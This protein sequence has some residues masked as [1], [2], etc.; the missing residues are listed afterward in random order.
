MRETATPRA[1]GGSPA[2][3]VAADAPSPASTVRRFERLGYAIAATD[4]VAIVVAFLLAYVI[5]FGPGVPPASFA[6]VIALVPPVWLT[7]F[8][9]WRLYA[10]HRFEPAEQFRRIVTAVSILITIVATLSFWSKSSYSRLWIGLSWVLSLVLVLLCHRAWHRWLRRHRAHGDLLLRTLIVGTNKEADALARALM[11]REAGFEPVGYVEF[12]PVD[13]RLNGLSI[14][15]TLDH[16][17]EAIERT[18]ADCLFVASTAVTGREMRAVSS[19]ARKAG[20]ELRVT[21]NLPETLSTRIAVQPIGR[22]MTLTFQPLG[23]SSAQAALKRSM[24]VGLSVLGL[25]LFAPVLATVAVAIRLGSS[26]PVLFRHERVGRRGRPFQ[27]LKF[28]TMV[29]GAVAPSAT[30]PTSI[31]A[32]W[33]VLKTRADPRVTAL[34]RFLR[35][36]SLDELPQLINVLRGEMSLVGPRPHVTREVA[37]YDQ[38]H[39]DRLEVRPGITGLWQVSGRTDLSFEECLRLDLYFID[40]WSLAYDLFILAKTV[41]VVLSGRGSF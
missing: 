31:D 32:L 27:L 11:D 19:V 36:W 21:A 17:N 12:G 10:I 28:R 3:L 41:P 4:T 20:L 9:I 34:G 24:D 14:V 33:P 6:L 1:S 40:N 18:G 29:D 35:R 39:F 15:G 23:L 5:K 37:Q 7:M 13:P 26:G 16:V 25:V 8:M 22:M 2:S 38:W 30:I